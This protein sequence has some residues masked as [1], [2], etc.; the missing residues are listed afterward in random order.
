[1]KKSA[2]FGDTSEDVHAAFTAYSID[3]NTFL[4]AGRLSS[5]SGHMV[6]FSVSS[7]ALELSSTH[8]EVFPDIYYT[9]LVGREQ[10]LEE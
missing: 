7:K 2:S 9:S 6:C 3:S 8:L 5:K 4:T 1:M 10:L